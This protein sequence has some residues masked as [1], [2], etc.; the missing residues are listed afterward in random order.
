MIDWLQRRLVE[1]ET[2]KVMVVLDT[3]SPNAYQHGELVSVDR[4][5]LVIKSS[6]ARRNDPD[7]HVLAQWKD[8]KFVKVTDK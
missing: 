5:G 4:R 8:I 3:E 7:T 1:D 2:V 6:P